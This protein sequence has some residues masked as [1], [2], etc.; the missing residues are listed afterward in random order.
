MDGTKS[1]NAAVSAQN[2]SKEFSGV[3]AIQD[4]SF[5]IDQGECFGLL[6]PNGAGKST[7]IKLIYGVM[8]RTR[9]ELNVL[10][11]DP[12][13]QARE[14][15]KHIGV[16]MQEDAL[17]EAMDVR[18]NMLMFCRFHNLWGRAAEQ[19]VDE[20]LDFMSL[21]TKAKAKISTLSGG[22][23]R[24]LA[25][26]RSLIAKPKLLILDE[27]TTG[28]DPA[29]RRL[30][31]ETIQN[32]KRSGTTIILTTHY[33]D[34]AEFLCD[35]LVLIDRGSIQAAGSP[36]Q[37]ID[38]HCS[39]YA[40]FFLDATQYGKPMRLECATLAEVAK[41]AEIQG[42]QPEM[43]RPANLEDVFLKLTGKDLH[44]Q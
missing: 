26:V 36:K 35:R 43:V 33:M 41:L 32:L 21:T 42:R 2:V 11:F 19:R 38:A 14:L 22:M 25:F 13:I 5:S 29:V 4:I 17:D 40:A 10:G 12:S 30:L 3:C 28:L 18:D 8:G 39:G 9:G 16:V 37:L 7:M 23:K 34:E 6:G 15:R 44:V 31:W 1:A 27:P 20:L 24:R